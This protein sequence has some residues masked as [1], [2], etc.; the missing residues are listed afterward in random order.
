M[1][2]S[3]DIE[4]Q[5]DGMTM[6]GRLAIPDGADRRP[7]VLIAHDGN[8]LDDHQRTRPEQL[9]ELGYVAFALDYH[10]QGRVYADPDQMLR[11]IDL[12]AKDPDQV[13]RLGL[14]GLDM[15][16]AEPR[17]D[18]SRLA[19]IGY[20]FGGTLVLEL[21]RGGADLKAVVGFHPGLSMFRAGTPSDSAN[22]TG[23]VL[24]CLGSEDP[25][26]PVEDRLEFE[27]DMRAAGVD[28]RMNLYGGAAHSFTHP[29]LTDPELRRPPGVAYHP[30]SAA[31][32]WRA[33][34]DLFNEVLT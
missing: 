5:V 10:G 4:Y 20:C 3:R 7:G 6:R 31:R 29:G 11:R 9:A 17:T 15:L 21:A 30:R 8:G 25:L 28:W 19:A 18:Q 26:I 16:C 13:R 27:R 1:V 33:M 32:A 12:L 34:I 24:V 2:T 23:A 22:I 14:A